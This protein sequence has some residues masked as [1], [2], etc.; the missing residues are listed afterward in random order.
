VV[1]FPILVNFPTQSKYS[2]TIKT[3]LVTRGLGLSL[4]ALLKAVNYNRKMCALEKQEN[5]R[6]IGQC[7]FPNNKLNRS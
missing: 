2:S 1:R 4:E 7:K 6:Q 3:Q 5:A